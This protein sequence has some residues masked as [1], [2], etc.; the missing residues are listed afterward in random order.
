M[1][2]FGVQIGVVQSWWQDYSDY[3]SRGQGLCYSSYIE[4]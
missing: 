3:S 1:K 4:D 2:T